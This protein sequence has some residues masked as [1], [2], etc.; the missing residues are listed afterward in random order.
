MLLGI[1]GIIFAIFFCSF[2]EI[3]DAG[4]GYRELLKLHFA[5][6][7]DSLLFHK[8]LICAKSMIGMTL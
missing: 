4:I 8:M 2:S 3:C 1:I 5:I 7:Q 6:L